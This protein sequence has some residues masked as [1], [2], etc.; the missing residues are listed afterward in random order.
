VISLLTQVYGQPRL[1]KAFTDELRG[2]PYEAARECELVVIDDCG[3]P[4]VHPLEVGGL[5]PMEVQLL[6]H[7][8]D[9]AW[10]QP[11]CRNLAARQARGDTLILLDPDMMIPPK[12]AIRFVREAQQL[13]QG[14]VLRFCLK[15]MNH[16]KKDMRG[17]VN[18]SSPNCWIICKADFEA[19]HGYNEE[20]AGH[21]GWSDVELL[22]VLDSAYDMRQD[23]SLTVDFYRRSG[24]LPDACVT[25]LDR[26]VKIN[27][28][29]HARNREIVR[30]KFSGNWHK[31]RMNQGPVS[32][33]LPSVRVI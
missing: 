5:L 14:H 25:T 31:W 21:K 12:K 19:V 33:N 15:E 10:A 16:P 20:F 32:R 29:K 11:A 30:K 24:A 8:R 18:L 2:W 28:K 26:E 22:H 1:L 4:A 7:T 27:L 23:S 3:D 6:R 17:K 9:L 13:Q